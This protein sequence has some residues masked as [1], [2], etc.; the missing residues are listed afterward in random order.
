MPEREPES[1][2]VPSIPTTPVFH[3]PLTLSGRPSKPDGVTIRELTSHRTNLCNDRIMVLSV[4]RP[5][6]GGACHRYR[7][8][9]PD[10]RKTHITFQDGPIAVV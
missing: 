6:A 8:Q 9:L 3:H 1:V 4:D 10:G 5:G 2:P 7:V